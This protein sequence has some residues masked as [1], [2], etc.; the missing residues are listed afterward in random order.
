MIYLFR[1]STGRMFPA[2]SINNKLR[3]EKQNTVGKISKTDFKQ[4]CTKK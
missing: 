2:G 1:N 4:K 3:R